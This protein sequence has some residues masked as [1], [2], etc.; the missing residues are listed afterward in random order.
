MCTANW[1]HIQRNNILTNRF[2]KSRMHNAFLFL[3]NSFVNSLTH[4]AV[5]YVYTQ[6]YEWSHAQRTDGIERTHAHNRARSTLR[7][8]ERASSEILVGR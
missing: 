3:T 6:F 2:P 8:C 5:V 4:N 7:T 1:W